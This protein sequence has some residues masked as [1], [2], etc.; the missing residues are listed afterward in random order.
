MPTAKDSLSVYALYQET[1]SSMH[2]HSSESF[3]FLILIVNLLLLIWSDE[4]KVFIPL[5]LQLGKKFLS[6]HGHYFRN[7]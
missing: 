2:S 6:I 4:N 3:F 5:R 7:I 1:L